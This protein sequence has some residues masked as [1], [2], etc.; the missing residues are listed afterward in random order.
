[1]GQATEKKQSLAS[2]QEKQLQEVAKMFKKKGLDCMDNTN[3]E[4]DYS[5]DPDYEEYFKEVQAGQ[6]MELGEGSGNTKRR[7]YKP[8]PEIVDDPLPMDMRH[9]RHSERSVRDEIYL[10]TTDLIGIGLSPREALAA[11]EIVFNQCFGR[12]FQQSKA[13]SDL[14]ETEFVPMEPIDQDTLPNE[15]SVRDVAERIETQGL[16]AEVNEIQ[17]RSKQGDIITHAGDSTTK[18][19]VRKFY[20]SGIHIN[21]ETRT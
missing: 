1:M 15:R 11:V 12:K 3:D 19:H 5:G 9:V 14:N 6:P 7:M 16:A 8:V 21:K 13:P 20:V 18:R 10:A 17:T 2:Y 4:E